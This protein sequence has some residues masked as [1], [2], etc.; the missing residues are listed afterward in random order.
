MSNALRFPARPSEGFLAIMVGFDHIFQKPADPKELSAVLDGFRSGRRT[1][2][3][4][5]RMHAVNTVLAR[6][7]TSEASDDG[8]KARPNFSV[9][10]AIDF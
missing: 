9:L 6:D 5:E 2:A 10:A 1:T 7:R 8:T 3:L 4:S